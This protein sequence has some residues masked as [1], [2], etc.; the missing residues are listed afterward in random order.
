MRMPAAGLPCIVSRTWVV[1]RP[2]EGI[3]GIL[4]NSW[5]SLT[6][7]PKRD[8]R[9]K[10]VTLQGVGTR[11]FTNWSKFQPLAASPAAPHKEVPVL[12]VVS[13][14]ATPAICTA[15]DRAFP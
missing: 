6:H 2:A 11:F 10:S 3:V 8:Y 5:E 15:T 12:K 9:Q 14:C 13:P 4:R 7:F 1:S